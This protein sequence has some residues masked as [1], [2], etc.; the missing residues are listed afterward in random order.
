MCIIVLVKEYLNMTD[1]EQL[2]MAL[3]MSLQAESQDME[4]DDIDAGEPGPS[5]EANSESRE[6]EELAEDPEF[7]EVFFQWLVLIKLFVIY[8]KLYATLKVS[9]HNML[10]RFTKCLKRKKPNSLTKHLKI[11]KLRKHLK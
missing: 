6:F 2:A 9:I 3:Q 1:E 10:F 5:Q 8:R 4:T 7:L 11:K